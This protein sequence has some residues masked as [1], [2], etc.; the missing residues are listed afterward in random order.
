MNSE[1]AQLVVAPSDGSLEVLTFRHNG[2]HIIPLQ[3]GV[4]LEVAP[5]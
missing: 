1:S 4:G 3:I 5:S 2:T